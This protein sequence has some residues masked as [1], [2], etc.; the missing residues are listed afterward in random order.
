MLFLLENITHRFCQQTL[1]FSVFLVYVLFPYIYYVPYVYYVPYIFYVPYIYY[2]YDTVFQLKKN[3]TNI[4]PLVFSKKRMQNNTVEFMKEY[5]IMQ[6][7]D[8]NHIV[9]LYGVVLDAAQEF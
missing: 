7:I 3:W 5:E 9:R 2:V 4:T 1:S 8:H 6:T